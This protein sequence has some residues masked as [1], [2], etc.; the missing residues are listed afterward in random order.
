VKVAPRALVLLL[1]STSITACASGDEGDD[2]DTGPPDASVSVDAGGDLADAAF[3][4]PPGDIDAAAIDAPPSDPP[5]AA[6][7]GEPDAGPSD[8]PDAGE[9]TPDAAPGPDAA[10]GTPDAAIVDGGTTTGVTI[11]F[12]TSVATTQ[13]GNTSGGTAFNDD[14]P[15]GEAL[16]GFAGSL[17]SSTG[18]HGKVGGVCGA[19]L[20]D[21]NLAVTVAA[22]STLP[23]HGILGTVAWTR[24]C[25]ANEVVVGFRGRSGSLIDQLTF[26]CAPLTVAASGGGYTV[27]VGTTDDLAS[28]G[29]SGGN[30]FAQT[31]CAAGSVAATARIRAGDGI[32]AFGLG[33]SPVTAQ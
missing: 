22:G 26:R 17:T 20:V 13:Y 23:L 31:D 27:T 33:C 14:C 32:D 7:T 8:P 9:T 19:V 6:E 15:A 30:A 3:D 1:V 16:I 5:D 25:P 21:D 24:T 11:S 28:I 29:G 10:E 4:A 12:G 2:D 18:Y